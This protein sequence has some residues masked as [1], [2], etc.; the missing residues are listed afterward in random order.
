MPKNKVAGDA[1]DKDEKKAKYSKDILGMALKMAEDEDEKD[2]KKDKKEDKKEK[3]ED[4][5]D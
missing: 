5:E 4:D 1:L 2:P 3:E